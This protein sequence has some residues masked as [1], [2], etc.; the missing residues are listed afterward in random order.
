[1]IL[2]RV[3]Q[4]IRADF[5]NRTQSLVALSFY[6]AEPSMSI[7]VSLAVCLHSASPGANEPE[8]ELVG[9]SVLVSE[10]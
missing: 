7:S 3:T 10:Q 1:M 5:S 9:I 8:Q 4:L 2:V 6:T